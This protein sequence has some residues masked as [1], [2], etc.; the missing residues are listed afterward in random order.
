[1]SKMYTLIIYV[2]HVV[3]VCLGLGPR[4][5]K[6]IINITIKNYMPHS[7]CCQICF[8]DP[9]DPSEVNHET[10]ESNM[11]TIVDLFASFDEH[12]KMK[13]M[14]TMMQRVLV[15]LSKAV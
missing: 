7:S 9:H 15:L 4:K 8:S 6:K 11:E 1:M 2:M 13:C 5:K 10:F 14:E 3:A 12:E